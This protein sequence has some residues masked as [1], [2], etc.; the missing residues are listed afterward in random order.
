MDPELLTDMAVF[1]AVVEQNGFTTAAETL[2]MSKSNVS[3]RISALE[4]RLNLKLI[5]RTT[6]KIGVTESGRLYYE[7]CARLVAEGRAADA[8]MMAMTSSPSG[9][10]NISLPET[11]GRS[12]ILPLLPKFLENHPNIRLNVTFCNRKVDLI[13]ERCDV[14]VR[15]GA[16]EDDTLCAVPLGASSQ[17]LFAAPAYLKTSDVIQNPSDLE[18]HAF[19]ASRTGFGPMKVDLRETSE[20]VSVTLLPRIGVRDHEAVLSLALAGMGVALLPAWLARE[21]V[22]SGELEEVLPKWRGPSVDFNAVFHPHRGMAPSLRVFIDF[23]KVQFK[24][25]R[26]LEDGVMIASRP[27]RLT[28]VN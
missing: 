18:K 23:L 9:L 12:F 27:P 11:L 2:N 17:F 16:I 15:K 28:V 13:E 22:V 4:D 20:V 25:H 1:A 8:A 10:L 19:I 26:P 6:R 3:R 5:H 7:Y 14:A 24:A 21:H